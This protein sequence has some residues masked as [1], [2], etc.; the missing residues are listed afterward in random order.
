[1][2][3]YLTMPTTVPEEFKHTK[4]T[5]EYLRAQFQQKPEHFDLSSFAGLDFPSKTKLN[6]WV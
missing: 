1:M 4:E 2:L 3:A 6:E 5:T